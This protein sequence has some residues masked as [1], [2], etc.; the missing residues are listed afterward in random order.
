M[1][2]TP[3]SININEYCLHHWYYICLHF[4]YDGAGRVPWWPRQLVYIKPKLFHPNSLHS[5]GN[6]QLQSVPYSILPPPLLKLDP[7]LEFQLIPQKEDPLSSGFNTSW[8]RT[9]KRQF[10]CHTQNSLQKDNF[11]IY[12]INVCTLNTL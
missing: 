1:G 8:Y 10:K 4:I 6:R 12:F 7:L 3:Q 2:K 9:Q 11:S 5:W